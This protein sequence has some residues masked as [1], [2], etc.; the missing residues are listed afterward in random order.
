[1]T[2]STTNPFYLPAGQGICEKLREV[3]AA[4]AAKKLALQF[5]SSE[6]GMG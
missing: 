6:R 2:L 1:M 4:I 3:K 5:G